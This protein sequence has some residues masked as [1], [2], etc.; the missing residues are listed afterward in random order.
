MKNSP[1]FNEETNRVE[2]LRRLNETPGITIPQD[3]ITRRPSVPLSL[4]RDDNVLRQFLSVL[5]W[6]ISEVKTRAVTES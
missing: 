4:L 3:A 6:L 2:L 1:P 5:D